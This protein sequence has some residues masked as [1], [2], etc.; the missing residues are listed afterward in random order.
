MCLYH[1]CG[2]IFNELESFEEEHC[3]REFVVLGTSEK[4]QDAN[5]PRNWTRRT[6]SLE[7]SFIIVIR[8]RRKSSDRVLE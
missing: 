7:S 1:N 8:M 2:K 6:K 4:Y 5:L 3:N